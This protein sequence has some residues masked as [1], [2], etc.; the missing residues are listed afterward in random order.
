METALAEMQRNKD[1]TI[2][3]SAF[4]AFV[5]RLDASVSPDV[6]HLAWGTIAV[7]KDFITSDN[8]RD[9]YK[10][11]ELNGLQAALKYRGKGVRAQ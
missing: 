1:G 7:G 10:V 11:V 2:G 6:I 5:Q 4:I 8:F 9:W 3:Y